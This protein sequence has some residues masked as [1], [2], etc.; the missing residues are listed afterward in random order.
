MAGFP[1]PCWVSV[2]VV[3]WCLTLQGRR[4]QAARPLDDPAQNSPLS[5]SQ[6]SLANGGWRGV[7]LEKLRHDLKE[8]AQRAQSWGPLCPPGTPSL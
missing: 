3:K 7:R 4:T 6:G 2:W 8:A 5:L 1:K